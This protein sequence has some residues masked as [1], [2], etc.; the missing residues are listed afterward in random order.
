MSSAESARQPGEDALALGTVQVAGEGAVGTEPDELH[1]LDRQQAP[2]EAAL[3]V[4]DDD[5][6]AAV[7]RDLAVCTGPGIGVLL[8]LLLSCGRLVVYDRA[9]AGPIFNGQF[10]ETT[11]GQFAA[12]LEH[13]PVGP[14]SLE[15]HLVFPTLVPRFWD[16][17]IGLNEFDGAGLVPDAIQVRVAAQHLVRVPGASVR[18]PPGRTL[19]CLTRLYSPSTPS[20][21]MQQGPLRRRKLPPPLGEA[22]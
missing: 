8:C 3:L 5:L 17:R 6:L 9:I 2:V 18:R 20:E 1:D 11:P 10:A 13:G 21:E 12:A 19:A 16:L 7:Q 15:S 4:V 22:R 14:E